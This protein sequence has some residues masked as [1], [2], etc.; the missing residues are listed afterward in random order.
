[1]ETVEFTY[2][3]HE[4]EKQNLVTLGKTRLYD[5]YKCKNCG[6]QGKSYRLG[7][8]DVPE[9]YAYKLKKCRCKIK[10]SQVKITFCR[11]V[12]PE[13]SKLTPGSIHNIIDPPAGENNSK[14]EWVQGLTEPVLLLSGEFVYV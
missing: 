12:G 8:I 6:I 2:G 9:K 14:G 5:I 7:S 3:G 10:H 13:F 4:W 11:A 1:M